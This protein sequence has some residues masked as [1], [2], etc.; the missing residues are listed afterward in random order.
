MATIEAEIYAAGRADRSTSARGPQLRQVLFDELKLPS[1]SEDARRRAEHGRRRCSKSWPPSTRC[2]GPADPSTASSPSSR[3]PI[4]TP[5]PTLV[6]S[7]G[8]PDPRLVQPGRR[9]DRAGSARATRTSRTSRSAPRTAGRSARRSSP[10][11]PGWSLLTADYSQIELRI[12]AHY[13][14]DPALMRAF[15]EDHDIHTRR[16]RA[17][18]RRRRGGGRRRPAAGGQD[19]QLRRHLRPEPVRPGQP[20]GDHPGGGRRVHRRLFPGIRRRR[21][22][23]SP[24]PSKSALAHG[25]GRDDPGPPPA[26]QRDQEHD[27]PEPQPGRADGRQHRHP[28]LGRR[29]D[30]AGHDPDRPASSA[31][32]DCQA[33]MLL[34]IHDELVFE[35]PDEEIPGLAE[36]V[37]REMTAALDLN[38][39]LEGRPRRRAELAGRRADI[40]AAS[41]PI[42]GV[43]IPFNP[44]RGGR[45]RP[46]SPPGRRR[47]IAVDPRR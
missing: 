18:L 34:Q 41:R 3:A 16:R 28:G 47:R 23:S 39:P 37:R 13:S 1:L 12:L 33:R 38:V 43:R 45:C 44:T 40:G 10:G 25:P 32:R 2:P 6:A 19:G 22:R 31:T 21:P 9:G 5:C 4:S 26:D 30:Q 29:P 11:S 27:R 36:L 8:R 42:A 24:R 15:A 46:A 35:A 17:D 20:A 7:R 14:D